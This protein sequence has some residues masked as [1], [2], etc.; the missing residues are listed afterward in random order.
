[1]ATRFTLPNGLR[2][3]H[4]QDSATAMVALDV[5]YNV[6]A[7][8]EH[9]DHTGMAHLF[10]HLMFGGSVNIA[11]F[12]GA[13]EQ[14]G[15]RN[16]AWTNQDYTNFYDI[17]PAQNAE[18]AFWLESDRMLSLAFS[19]K[20][21]EVQRN[22]VM[23]EFKQV[24]LNQPYGD[25]GHHMSAL[26]YKVHP[27]RT[28]VIGKELGHIESVTQEQVREFFR[29][30]YAPNNAVLAVTGN[31]TL[32]ETRRLAEKWF[33]PIPRRIVA[34]RT[35]APEPEQ[36]EA[37]RIV[38]TGNVP[39]T[40]VVISY[41]MPSCANPDYPVCDIIT[42]LLAAGRTSRYYRRLVMESGLF[43]SAD[44]SI[45]GS[46]EP[47]Q[48]LLQGMLRDGVSVD[49]ACDALVDVA[50]SLIVNPPDDHELQSA[51]NR[52]ETQQV[53]G[54]ISYVNLASTLAL[55]EM[56]NTTQAKTLA[57]YMGITREDIVRVASYIFRQ[58]RSSTLIYCPND[59]SPE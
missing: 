6:G 11:D 12:D 41:P 39:Q 25:L 35:Y 7:R 34:P 5:L 30:H 18:T 17:V 47:G 4:E 59:V 16:N 45:T 28:P 1:M 56:R 36:T 55:D 32:D 10:E 29:T 33:G 13:I 22:V 23:E 57:C 42:D 54:N 8:D 27:Y 52:F 50:R 3:V 26:A 37:R 21:L 44:A 51:L 31:I 2:V 14:A 15:G 24:C 53:M 48:L 19:D 46:E 20:A 40:L 43:S 49:E 58:E 9:P 38:V